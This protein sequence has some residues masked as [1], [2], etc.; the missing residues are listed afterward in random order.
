M[1]SSILRCPACGTTTN[2]DGVAFVSEW[3]VACHVAGSIQVGERLHRAWARSV[4]PDATGAGAQLA[5]KLLLVVKAAMEQT[6]GPKNPI[7][8]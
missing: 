5:E 2:R 7:G 6:P 1:G 4:C 3:A 8:F